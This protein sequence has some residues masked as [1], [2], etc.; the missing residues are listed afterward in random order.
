MPALLL[1]LACLLVG[2]CLHPVFRPV[3]QQFFAK[4]LGAMTPLIAHPVWKNWA[5]VNLDSLMAN[6]ALQ[7]VSLAT[8]LIVLFFEVRPKHASKLIIQ[9]GKHA[10]I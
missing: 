9:L 10:S 5:M 6:M 8:V 1:L 4:E 2:H 3:P 7:D